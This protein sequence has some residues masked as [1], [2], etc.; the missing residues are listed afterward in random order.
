MKSK[1]KKKKERKKK[2]II[3]QIPLK[4]GQCS[5]FYYPLRTPLLSNTS[6]LYICQC[7]I[8]NIL[9]ILLCP[10]SSFKTPF[11][12]TSSRKS[13][14]IRHVSFVLIENLSGP[15]SIHHIVIMCLFL[16]VPHQMKDQSF[17]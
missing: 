11:S 2:K 12:V 9:C 13:S 10:V 17:L 6:S 8:W 15:L 1:K 7:L 16:C 5:Y 14:T 3:A 4:M